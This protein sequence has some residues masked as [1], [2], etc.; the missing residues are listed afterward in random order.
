MAR[1]REQ[2]DPASRRLVAVPLRAAGAALAANRGVAPRAVDI[3]ELQA[4]LA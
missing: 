2:H 1:F 4:E 3:A